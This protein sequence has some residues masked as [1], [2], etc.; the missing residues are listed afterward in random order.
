MGR[1]RQIML[2]IVAHTL[3]KAHGSLLWY[4]VLAGPL[5]DPRIGDKLMRW[6]QFGKL[7]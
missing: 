4:Q 2:P 1:K 6:V 3:K 7:E 5:G